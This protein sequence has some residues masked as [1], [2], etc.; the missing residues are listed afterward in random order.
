[1]FGRWVGVL[2]ALMPAIAGTTGMHYRRFLL[3]TAIGG[4]IWAIAVV[5][6]AYF[7]GASWHRVQSYLGSASGILV[8]AVAAAIVAFIVVRRLRRRRQV[9]EE[10]GSGS[11][12]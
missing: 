2:R 3:F 8:G 6:A 1:L 11:R 9:A 7:A 4:S 12:M 5:V 10:A